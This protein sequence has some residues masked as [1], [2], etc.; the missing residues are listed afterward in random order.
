MAEQSVERVLEI[1][2]RPTK[3][4]LGVTDSIEELCCVALGP[5]LVLGS[6]SLQ[7]RSQLPGNPWEPCGSASPS[8]R[9]SSRWLLEQGTD[10]R[11][12]LSPR[13]SPLLGLHPGRGP[14]AVCMVLVLIVGALLDRSQLPGN[15]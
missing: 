1:V 13:G 14:R 12:G 11:T 6:L 15:P 9:A 7:A 10:F 8:C 2:P 4:V 5:S 3:Q